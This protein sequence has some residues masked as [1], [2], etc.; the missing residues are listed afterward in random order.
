M[1]LLEFDVS[2]MTSNFFDFGVSWRTR[3][4]Q[5]CSMALCQEAIIKEVRPLVGRER[6][7][8]IVRIGDVNEFVL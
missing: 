8:H 4:M 6:R 1:T 3:M 2:F 7:R 5:P